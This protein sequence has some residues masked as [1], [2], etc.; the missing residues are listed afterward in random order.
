MYYLK[1]SY[2]N[3]SEYFITRQVFAIRGW[4]TR[5]SLQHVI[6]FNTEHNYQ[7][8]VQLVVEKSTSS[9]EP[10]QTGNLNIFP[11]VELMKQDEDCSSSTE[12]PTLAAMPL[13]RLV[14][15]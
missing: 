2:L 5:I 4:I 15:G 9:V 7:L 10:P 1:V 14:V 12:Y 6:L 13:C 8:V 3:L 11:L